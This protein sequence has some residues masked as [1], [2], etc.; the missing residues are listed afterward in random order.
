MAKLRGS[1]I[2]T[3]NGFIKQ[4]PRA[5]HYLI[6]GAHIV[7]IEAEDDVSVL[8][9]QNKIMLIE[10]LKAKGKTNVFADS[11][12]DLWGTLYNWAYN[13]VN[14]ED[15][16]RYLEDTKFVLYTTKKNSK[17]GKC[18]VALLN[19][20]Q[21]SNFDKVIETCESI[22]E[23]STDEI[24]TYLK[25]I[26][27][28]KI[29]SY[30]VIK[31]LCVETPEDDISTDL[32]NLITSIYKSFYTTEFEA[33]A[34]RLN[35]WFHDKIVNRENDE[36]KKCSIT[37]EDLEKFKAKFNGYRTKVKYVQGRLSE[38]EIIKMEKKLFVSQ[39]KAINFDDGILTAKNAYNDWKN[40]E[41]KDLLDG[42]ATQEI[43][44][45]TYSNLK[46][47]W[48]QARKTIPKII[49][50][51][52]EDKGQFLYNEVQKKEVYIDGVEIQGDK[53]VISRGVHNYLANSDVNHQHSI[54]WHPKYEDKF[55]EWSTNE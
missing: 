44:N 31:N 48:E 45:T 53:Q 35:G 32:N 37:K 25:Y 1:K 42:K 33:F 14:E 52:D 26:K 51:T 8:N 2:E 43:L 23:S 15:K 39:L 9:R 18:I 46:D 50:P 19:I 17:R 21:E 40:F 38:E 7:N 24:K 20:G 29:I 5:M 13:Y 47:N 22:L 3:F 34:E 6:N 41:D 16:S 54:G 55:K 10:Q 4:V 36:L 28:N 49:Y 27:E 11:S 12:V 30:K